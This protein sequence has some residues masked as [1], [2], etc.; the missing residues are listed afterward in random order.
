[1]AIN[2][3][4]ISIIA[5]SLFITTLKVEEKKVQKE[6]KNIPQIVFEDSIMFDINEEEIVQIV[7]SRQ[8]LNYKKR[9]ELYDVTII[10]RSK[11]NK[12]DTISAEYILKRDNYYKLYQNVNLSQ[13][14]TMRLTTDFLEYNSKTKIIQNNVEFLLSYNNSNLEGNNIFFDTTNNIIKAKNTHFLIN[15]K[16]IIK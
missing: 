11:N 3:F 9:D 4:I 15:T 5:F 1:M 7:Q 14:D 6:Y 2:I 10:T 12:T 16:E 8:A 13:G